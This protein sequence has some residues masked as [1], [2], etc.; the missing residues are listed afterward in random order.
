MEKHDTKEE[1]ITAFWKMY[2]KSPIEKISIGKLCEAAGYNRATFYNH[3]NNIYDLLD[4]AIYG[5]LAPAKHM[6]LTE[7][8]Y[9]L[10]QGNLIFDIIFTCFRQQNKYIAL[11]FKRRDF[12][13]LGEQIKKEVLS[14]IASNAEVESERLCRIEVLLEYHVS[15]ILGVINSWYKNGAC[16]AEQDIL[17][18][19]YNI[20]EKGVLPSLK[21]ELGVE[22]KNL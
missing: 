13:V 12:Y 16:I 7:N 2:E 17:Q 15:A 5:I 11:L 9:N 19:I 20:S 10:L 1:F 14:H 4:K 22:G 6:L 18:Q 8:F 21:E 3:F